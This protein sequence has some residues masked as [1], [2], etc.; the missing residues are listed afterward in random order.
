MT[1]GPTFDDIGGDSDPVG[2]S[3]TRKVQ[4]LGRVDIPDEY[5]DQINCDRGE[6]VFVVCEEDSIRIVKAT[7]DRVLRDA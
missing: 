2:D 5:L 7:A 1:D 6:K 3:T 4:Q